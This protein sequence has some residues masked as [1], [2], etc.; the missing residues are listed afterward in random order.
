[1]QVRTIEVRSG[2]D[3]G[4]A[5]AELRRRRRLTQDAAA[6]KS[7][8]SKAYLSKIET[9][10]TSALLNHVV[11]VLR[12]LGATITVSFEDVTI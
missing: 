2:E 3:F 8:I 5:I 9:G 1:M 6:D 7:G 11:R 4:R 10:R 12:R